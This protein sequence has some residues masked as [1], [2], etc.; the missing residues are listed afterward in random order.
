M[1]FAII[2]LC[3]LGAT[4]AEALPLYG[5]REGRTCDNCHTL[6]NRWKNPEKKTDRKCTLSCSGCHVDPTGGGLRTTSGRFYGETVLPMAYA[7]YRNYKDTANHLAPRVKGTDKKGDGAPSLVLGKPLGA[8]SKMALAQGRY[9]KMNADPLLA[10]GVDFRFAGWFPGNALV[11][12]MQ[13]DTQASLHPVEHFSIYVNAGVL[14]KSRSLAAIAENQHPYAVKDAMLLLNELPGNTYLKVGRFLPPFGMRTDDHTTFTRRD[15]EL[16]QG[17]QE[18]R[19]FGAELGL[20]PNYPYL[21]AAVFRPGQK[22]L[23][24]GAD[25]NNVEQPSFIGEPGEVGAAVSAGY[26]ELGWQL[27]VS[28]MTR[29]RALENGGNTDTLSAQWGVNPWFYS[30]T[31]KL[32]YLG[33]YALGRYQR[34]VSGL[35]TVQA[36]SSQELNYAPF[37]GLNFRFK[38]DWDDPDFEVADDQQHRLSIGGDI[39]LIPSVRLTYMTRFTLLPGRELE[40]TTDFFMFLRTWL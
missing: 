39:N 22:D 27:G 32:T 7:P 3:L 21:N 31:L 12:P 33:E 24:N 17:L 13:L 26:R 1:R 35:E 34:E 4:Y 18:S 16:D 36:A 25:P 30:D 14:S 19:V 28:A 10:F 23:L 9:L 37:N 29:R 20:A 15:F 6:P 5:A 8:P 11:F 38:Y 40:G 2:A